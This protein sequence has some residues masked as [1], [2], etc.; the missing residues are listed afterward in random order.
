MSGII[1]TAGTVT[2][3]RRGVGAMLVAGLAAGCRLRPDES[4][5]RIRAGD[6]FREAAGFDGPRPDPAWWRGFGSAELDALMER[7]TSANLD[8]A[9]AAA[10]VR[11]ADAAVRIA[12]AALLPEVTA[13]V[14]QGG[15]GRPA[16]AP[17]GCRGRTGSRPTCPRITRSISGGG[18][19]TTSR[20]TS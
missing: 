4:E 20:S 12:G 2:R 6:R 11:Q 9:A 15:A 10:R 18:S 1:G 7:A 17:G 13:G 16:G 8:L 3:T 5:A 14:T 19:G